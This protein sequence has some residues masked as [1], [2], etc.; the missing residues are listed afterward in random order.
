MTSE[1]LAEIYE[2]EGQEGVEQAIDF[3]EEWYEIT[4]ESNE[5]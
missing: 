1:E 5:L 2:H 3:A 4:E